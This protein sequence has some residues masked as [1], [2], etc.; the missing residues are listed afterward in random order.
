MKETVEKQM[1]IN[2]ILLLLRGRPDSLFSTPHIKNGQNGK[3]TGAL[4]SQDDLEENIYFEVY[5]FIF[6][7]LGFRDPPP[8]G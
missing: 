4:W 5:F 8:A 1:F 6:F 7:H 3:L 2:T